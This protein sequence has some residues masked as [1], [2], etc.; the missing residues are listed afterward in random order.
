MRGLVSSTGA[1]SARLQASLAELDRYTVQRA[2]PSRVGV[3]IDAY[4]K[5]LHRPVVLRV[6]GPDQQPERALDGARAASR[7]RHPGVVE[8]HDAGVLGPS[9]ARSVYVAIERLAPSLSL[10]AW[11]GRGPT[12]DEVRAV[13]YALAQGL[14]AAHEAGVV[15]GGLDGTAARVRS[16]GRVALIEFRGGD[17]TPTDDQRALARLWLRATESWRS[18]RRDAVLRRAVDPA[19]RD[20]FPSVDALRRAVAEAERARPWPAIA[21]LGSFTF[22]GAVWWSQTKSDEPAPCAAGVEAEGAR[23]WSV[24]RADA[25]RRGVRRSGSPQAEATLERLVP[26]VDDYVERWAEGAAAVCDAGV[27]DPRVGCYAEARAELHTVLAMFESGDSVVTEKALRTVLELPDVEQCDERGAGDMAR[28]GLSIAMGRL[29]ALRRA[30]RDADAYALA[31]DLLRR[32]EL[33]VA[34]RARLHVERGYAAFGQKLLDDAA[35]E[36]EAGYALAIEAGSPREQVNAASLLVM[37][38][39]YEWRNAELAEL[40]LERARKAASL[41]GA[42]ASLGPA[43]D[44]AASNFAYG[45]GEYGKALELIE[46]AIEA[47]IEIGGEDDDVAWSMRNNRAVNLRVRSRI[48]DAIAELE[49]YLDYQRRTY[50]TMQADVARTYNNLGS[51]FVES[52]RYAEAI[53][54]L[55]RA[56]E[57]WSASKGDDYPDLGMAFTN[58]GRAHTQ[59]DHRA[60]AVADLQAAI[61]VWTEAFGPRNFRV[62]IA[63]N[64]LSAAYTTFG[65]LEAAATE[66]EAAY[67]IQVANSGEMHLDNAYPLTN[68]ADAMIKLG[69]L[70]EARTWAEEAVRVT[71]GRQDEAPL[72]YAKAVIIAADVRLAE[73]RANRRNTQLRAAAISEVRRACAVSDT[74]PEPLYAAQ[75]YAELAGELFDSGAADAKDVA[76]IAIDRIDATEAAGEALAK[77]RSSLLERSKDPP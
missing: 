39:G 57:I 76:R 49:A 21:A 43:V 2:L 32:P 55:G 5:R 75:C 28:P 69:R 48:P 24:E 66:A 3:S 29:L 27:S 77:M 12:R 45:Q 47:R 15:H 46:R 16:D 13:F 58:R 68:L 52:G 19:L 25:V 71:A 41:P 72:E 9:D 60:E 62:A 40:W 31:T 51:A 56:A 38:H 20:P 65:Q 11:L 7:V 30:G 4:D 54:S 74:I 50:G 18:P 64:N 34:Y 6:Y 33:P 35:A 73:S 70:E 8:I 53:E 44:Q 17:A 14:H 37:L 63:R 22:C 26:M 10:R 1:M 23:V 42:P 36:C 61:D 67:D 59:L